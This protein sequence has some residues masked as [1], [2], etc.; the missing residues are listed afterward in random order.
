VLRNYFVENRNF[1]PLLL[2]IA[3]TK[4]WVRVIQMKTTQGNISETA[5]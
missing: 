2:F 1:G 5:I 3:T 4:P